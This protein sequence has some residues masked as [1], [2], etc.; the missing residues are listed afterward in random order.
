MLGTGI[1]PT[2]AGNVLGSE[3]FLY[4]PMIVAALFGILI[5]IVTTRWCSFLWI[6]EQGWTCAIAKGA[7]PFR[8]PPFGHTWLPRSS[9]RGSA[10]RGRPLRARAT[11]Y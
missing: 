5:A 6:A 9:A 4:S 3:E 2:T 11:R 8:T 1:I 10:S 7:T